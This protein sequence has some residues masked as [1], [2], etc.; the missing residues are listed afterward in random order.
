MSDHL[1]SE[2]N[3]ERF[4]RSQKKNILWKKEWDL[5]FQNMVHIAV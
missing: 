1:V 4:V 5:Y 2:L 3:V